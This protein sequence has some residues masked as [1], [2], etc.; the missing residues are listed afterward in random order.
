LRGYEAFAVTTPAQRTRDLWQMY[1]DHEWELAQHLGPLGKLSDASP[2][3]DEPWAAVAVG[4]VSEL[5][6]WQRLI[7]DE[8]TGGGLQ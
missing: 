6:L 7:L 4:R 1:S 3:W 2:V 5:V 8:L